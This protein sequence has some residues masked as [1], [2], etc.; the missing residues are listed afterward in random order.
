MLILM[1]IL[2]LIGCTEIQH[3]A[4]SISS[5]PSFTV[6]KCMYAVMQVCHHSAE[7]NIAQNLLLYAFKLHVF[8]T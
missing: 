7:Q 2:H 6:F 1:A 4:P 3:V 5:C 8:P